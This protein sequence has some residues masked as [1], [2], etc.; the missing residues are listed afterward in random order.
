MRLARWSPGMRAAYAD[1]LSVALLF[2][3]LAALWTAGAL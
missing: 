3:I 1:L 2:T